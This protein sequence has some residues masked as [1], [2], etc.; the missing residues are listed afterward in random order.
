MQRPNLDVNEA[1]AAYTAAPDSELEN[2][3]VAAIERYAKK[4]VWIKLH[5]D[6]P[7]IVNEAVQSIM[8]HLADFRGNSKFS[9]W[10]FAVVVRLCYREIKLKVTTKETLFSDLKE[11]EVDGLATYELDGDAKITL[12]RLRKTLS[13]Q[14]NHRID[15]R[16]QGFTHAEIA[17]MLTTTTTAIEGRWRRLCEKLRRA[18]K[19]KNRLYRTR[20]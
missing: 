20:N 9:T 17:E 16:L 5:Q 15:L 18:E 1:F 13:Q 14:E 8:A 10:V 12:D 19:K 2:A 11:H 7:E 4:I 6:H 3:L